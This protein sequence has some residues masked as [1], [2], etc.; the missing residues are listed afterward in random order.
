MKIDA[1]P[2]AA[3]LWTGFDMRTRRGREA[4]VDA[5]YERAVEVVRKTGR[6]S[7]SHLQRQLGICYSNAVRLVDE[8]AKRGIVG[9]HRLGGREILARL[10]K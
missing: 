9:P 5:W 6:A 7:V 3:A 1:E 4:F 8:L 10:E 2:T